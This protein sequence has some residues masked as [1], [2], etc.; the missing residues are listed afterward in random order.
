M[1]TSMNAISESMATFA[2]AIENQASFMIAIG[3][4]LSLQIMSN[5]LL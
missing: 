5:Y 3:A 1:A 4:Y 2:S